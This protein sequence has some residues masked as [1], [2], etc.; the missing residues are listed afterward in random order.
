SGTGLGLSIA[1][2]IVY[3]HH[4]TL[5]LDTS[6]PHTRFVIQLPKHHLKSAQ[7]SKAALDSETS[8]LFHLQ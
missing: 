4:G 1:R 6:S 8:T 5:T 3:A 2:S 7:T